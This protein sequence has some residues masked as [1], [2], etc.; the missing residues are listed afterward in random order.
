MD[1]EQNGR[2]LPSSPFRV[3]FE[4]ISACNMNCKY[5]YAQPFSNEVPTLENLKYLFK[6]TSEEA[7]AF[8]VVLLGGE[9]FL[10]KDILD[11]IKIAADTFKSRIGISTNGTLLANLDANSMERLKMLEKE[12]KVSIQVSI[13]TYKEEVN[14]KLRG[15]TKNTIKGMDAL[16]MEGIPFGIGMVVTTVNKDYIIETIAKFANKYEN[17]SDINIEPLQP[18]KKLGVQYFALRV[19]NKEMNRI[20]EEAK[21]VVKESGKPIVI[22]DDEKEF[23]DILSTY[24]F[25]HCL[26]GLTR[27]GVLSNGDVTPCV[28]LRDEVIG[29][30]YKES[31]QE[32]WEKSKKRFLR[33][34][35]KGN[36]CQINAKSKEPA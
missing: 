35:L 8:S 27:S 10:R 23:D 4:V 1:A 22:V 30:L 28:T 36:Q 15:M 6:K 31:W 5:C 26:A 24:N 32:I 21:K 13:D 14:D 33:L 12:G 18:T 7:N 29:N 34:D 11:V 2:L 20:K 19:D 25:K 9:P 17:L 16:D 3:E